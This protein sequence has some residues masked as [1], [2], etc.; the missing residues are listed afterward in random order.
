MYYIIADSGVYTGRDLNELN[1]VLDSKIEEEEFNVVG[2][3]KVCKITKTD[4]DFIQDKKRLSRIFFGNFFK[5]DTRPIK[6]MV[7]GVLSLSLIIF[8]L[9]LTI[10]NNLN[11]LI[12]VLSVVANGS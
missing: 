8:L 9:T 2:A 4:L 5:S 1:K 3:D 6:F 11:Q 12:E 7:L 10:S